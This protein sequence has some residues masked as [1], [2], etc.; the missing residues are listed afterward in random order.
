M[1]SY[2]DR[3][4]PRRMMQQNPYQQQQRPK[5]LLTSLLEQDGYA[6]KFKNLMGGGSGVADAAGAAGAGAGLAG[7]GGLGAAAAGLGPVGFLLPML[8]K[9][10][11]R[12]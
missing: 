11:G 1:S 4:D 10:F 2:V 9:R 7:A 5:G 12:G 8:L 6:D 3:G